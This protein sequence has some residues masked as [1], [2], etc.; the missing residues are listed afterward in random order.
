MNKRVMLA[1]GLI[2]AVAFLVEASPVLASSGAQKR[3]TVKM[4]AAEI[5]DAVAHADHLGLSGDLIT[6]L[7]PAAAST[8]DKAPFMPLGKRLGGSATLSGHVLSYDGSP[9][10]GAEVDWWTYDDAN[11]WQTAWIDTDAAGGYG[12]TGLPPAAGTGEVLVYPA[13]GSY[14][15]GRYWETWADGSSNT[16]DFRPGKVPVTL[17]AESSTASWKTGSVWVWT[18][19]GGGAEKRGYSEIHRAAGTTQVTGQAYAMPGSAGAGAVVKCW[20]NVGMEVPFNGTVTAGA[21]SSSSIVADERKALSVYILVPWWESGRPGSKVIFALDKFPAGRETSVTGY[22]EDPT[23]DSSHDFGTYVS[24]GDETEFTTAVVPK[25]AT[26]GYSYYFD[27]RDVSGRLTL[28]TYFQVATLKSSR[29]RTGSG[30]SIR[31]SG[32]VPTEGHWGSKAGKSKTVT[33]YQRL[34]R[35]PDPLAWNALTKGWRKLGTVRANGLGRYRSSLLH[36]KRTT[37]YVLRYPGD[38]WYGV[39]YTDPVK[40][41]VR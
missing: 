11:G 25:T 33:M 22:S 12:F 29:S 28:S 13:D 24:G 17:L 16:F 10:A 34:T 23:N 14:T 6:G 35:I 15:L 21:V 31:L 2:L 8:E 36:P 3:P 40:V 18:K 1:L 39:G 7:D 37:W 38:D 9:L 32:I 20:I 19:D 30:G 5:R 26:P 4:S 41:T 27:F